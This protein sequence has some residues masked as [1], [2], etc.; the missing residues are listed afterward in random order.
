MVSAVTVKESEAEVVD[1][2][3]SSVSPLALSISA[4]DSIR[5]QALIELAIIKAEAQLSA[6]LDTA[7]LIPDTKMSQYLK[8]NSLSKLTG[9]LAETTKQKLR[10]AITLAV[11][12]GGTADDIVGAIKATVKEF[13]SVRAELIAQTEVNNAYNF[14]RTELARSAGFTEKRWVTES[15]NPCAICILNEAEG[16]IGIDETF[17]SGNQRPTAHPRCVLGKTMVLPG[18]RV[19]KA[20]RRRYEGAIYEFT[21][22]DGPNLSIT[23][24]HPILTAGGWVAASGLSSGDQVFQRIGPSQTPGGGSGIDPY[25]N[26]G[27]T[28]IE[29]VFESL[30]MSVGCSTTSVPSSSEA[31]HGDGTVNQEIEIVWAES[32]LPAD[33]TGKPRKHIVDMAFADSDGLGVGL[34]TDSR[35]AQ[36]IER[37]SASTGN[38]VS[39]SDAGLFGNF[40]LPVAPDGLGVTHSTSSQAEKIPASQYGGPC[41][42][43]ASGNREEG[44]ASQ[45]R[46]VQIVKIEKRDFSGHVYNL[47]TESGCYTADSIVVHNCYCSLDFRQ[48][49]L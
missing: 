40:G 48:V 10:D 25:L 49:T 35:I 47:E 17:L 23:P 38:P 5:Y 37:S 39:F 16:Y 41:D 44:L 28:T 27:E 18:G 7:A 32:N 13:S 8:T 15:G 46:L 4:N 34:P 21:F 20:F 26:H 11:R 31:F 42:Q 6:Q 43:T 33:V 3:M 29:K 12:S 22:S 30:W 19:T 2:W 45:V 24:N 14:G 36:I 1:G 9:T